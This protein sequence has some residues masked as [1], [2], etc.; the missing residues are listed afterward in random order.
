MFSVK[1]AVVFAS[2]QSIEDGPEQ[3]SV[4]PFTYQNNAEYRYYSAMTKGLD[5]MQMIDKMLEK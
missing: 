4:G 3:D 1:I 2:M 5:T